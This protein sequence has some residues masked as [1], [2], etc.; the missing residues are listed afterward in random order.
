MAT[1]TAT[2]T[3]HHHHDALLLLSDA[4]TAATSVVSH[5]TATGQTMAPLQLA[6]E[7]LQQQGVVVAGMPVVAAA[8]PQLSP[9]KRAGA[10]EESEAEIGGKKKIE[11][12]GKDDEDL[13]DET[14]DSESDNA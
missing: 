3:G 6:A 12:A 5:A 1:A 8:A 9:K 7:A 4:A 10:V 11:L 13:E 14:S 2:A